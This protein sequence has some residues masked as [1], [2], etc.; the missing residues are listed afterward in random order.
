MNDLG[1]DFQHLKAVAQAGVDRGDPSVADLLFKSYTAEAKRLHKFELKRIAAMK[2][3][4]M[5]NVLAKH[6]PT[7][8]TKL[9]NPSRDP[10]PVWGYVKPTRKDPTLT[11]DI[12]IH[13]Q[14]AVKEIRTIYGATVRALMQTIKPLDSLR[15]DISREPPNPLRFLEQY[16]QARIAAY[17]AWAKEWDR[18]VVTRKKKQKPRLH[19]ITYMDVVLAVLVD[20]YKLREIARLWGL[21]ATQ[22]NR[23]FRRCLNGY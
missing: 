19:R 13:Q 23:A 1:R 9:P 2:A 4:E 14:W 12:N 18:G 21:D 7:D 8:L 22:I 20:G 10:A 17:F 15:V 3:Q 11:M 16:G 5:A 6:D